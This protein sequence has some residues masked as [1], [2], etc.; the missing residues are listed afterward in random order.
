MLIQ[1][2]GS[3]HGRFQPF[4]NEHLDYI[5]EAKK[6]C[7]FLWIGLTK[8]DRENLTNECSHRELDSSNPW[9][10]SE[11]VMMIRLALLEAG[12][13]L[14]KF[15]FIPFPIDDPHK[16][17]LYIPENVICYTTI[18][19][20]WNIEK[21]KRLEKYGYQVYVLK[22]DYSEDRLQGT[23]IRELIRNNN[24]SWTTMVPK[25]VSN[26]IISLNKKI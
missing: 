8:Y 7:D 19:E 10:Y 5:L 3:V 24:P 11:R 4:H 2:I 20:M 12:I 26:F 25:A 9:M 18:R 17:S 1:K 22:E 6:R 21:I 23:N 15:A 13:P 14:S 16:I